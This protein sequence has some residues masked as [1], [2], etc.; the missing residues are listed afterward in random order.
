MVVGE[1]AYSLLGSV[2]SKAAHLVG[3]VRAEGAGPDAQA[4]APALARATIRGLLY[5]QPGRR[6]RTRRS[7]NVSTQCFRPKL[8]ARKSS[9]AEA[10]SGLA[11]PR[12]GQ[13]RTLPWEGL[14]GQLG[15]LGV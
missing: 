10:G 7:A 15:R 1:F 13:R 8:A 11:L 4:Q 12:C 3:L 9:E 5:G 14:R 2:P 6:L